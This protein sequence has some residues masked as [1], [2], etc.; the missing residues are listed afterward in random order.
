L[1]TFSGIKSRDP[2]GEIIRYEWDFGDGN[3]GKGV[4]VDHAYEKR[5]D[6]VVQLKVIDDQE[7][8]REKAMRIKVGL[9]WLLIG[10]II[11]FSFFVVIL[12]LLFHPKSHL[13]HKRLKFKW[14]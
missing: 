3:I 10:F 9:N 2:D 6:Y 14:R 13:H 12:I 5:G 11:L 8:F 1:V 7:E 4:I